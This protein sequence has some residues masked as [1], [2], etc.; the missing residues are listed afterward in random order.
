MLWPGFDPWPG[1]LSHA[2]GGTKKKKR[3]MEWKQI[4]GMMN[5]QKN[6]FSHPYFEILKLKSLNSSAENKA[7][8]TWNSLG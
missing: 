4:Y 5:S 7:F 3:K 8:I 6:P 2:M 1:E